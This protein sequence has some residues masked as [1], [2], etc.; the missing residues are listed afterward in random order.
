MSE[1]HVVDVTEMLAT[2]LANGS[3]SL[4]RLGRM[5]L[6]LGTET[7]HGTVAGVRFD[8][9]ER[10]YFLR[11]KGAVAFMPADVIEGHPTNQ[12]TTPG[13]E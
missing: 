8:G 5:P 3:R 6:P 1:N 4:H 11:S 2:Q 13:K 12:I 7:D 9:V 10:Y